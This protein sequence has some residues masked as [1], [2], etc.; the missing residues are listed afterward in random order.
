MSAMWQKIKTCTCCDKKEKSGEDD[1]VFVQASEPSPWVK[2]LQSTEKY[3]RPLLPWLPFALLLCI[4]NTQPYAACWTAFGVSLVL[5]L[6]DFIQSRL[7]GGVLNGGVFPTTLNFTSL[8]VYILLIIVVDQNPTFRREYIGPVA[9]TF[10]VAAVFFSLVFSRPFTQETTAS[11]VVDDK[12]HTSAEFLKFNQI[13]TGY[14]LAW[15]LVLLV[16]IW[17][18]AGVGVLG[19]RFARFANRLRNFAEE[20]VNESDRQGLLQKDEDDEEGQDALE[21]Q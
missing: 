11:L 3:L 13:L 12:L 4:A 17:V 16:C 20:H 9:A 7:V 15:L 10:L 6:N 1:E 5:N 18:G 14:V 21:K 2:S 19:Q 8:V